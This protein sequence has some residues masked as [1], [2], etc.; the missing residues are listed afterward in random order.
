MM[1]GRVSGEASESVGAIA[2]CPLM[3]AGGV[4][5]YTG[6]VDARTLPLLRA[7]AE[8][9]RAEARE[10]LVSDPVDAERGG[11]P[12]RKFL[13]APGGKLQTAFLESSWLSGTLSG[14]VGLPVRPTGG[15][16][17]TYYCR[18]G[19]HLALHRDIR[20]CDLAV[21]TALE[22]HRP[23]NCNA[24][25]LALYPGRTS[26]QLS[27]IRARPLE[28]RV[29]LHLEAGQTCVMLGGTVPHELL[30]TAPTQTRVVSVLCFEVLA[31]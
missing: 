17:F 3:R 23:T 30:P 27:A 8:Q 21:I 24:G 15:G 26:E 2:C 18:T 14:I 12:R 19:D 11:A 4:A 10:S 7:E 13:S 9:Q 5:V 22:A 25:G 20:R 1:A 28:G 29:V 6:F 16:T 31:D